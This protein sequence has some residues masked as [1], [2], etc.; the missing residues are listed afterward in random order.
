M[1]A[2]DC[3]KSYIRARDSLSREENAFRVV[4]FR[5]IYIPRSFLWLIT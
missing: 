3:D 1:G 5:H 4:L 2:F